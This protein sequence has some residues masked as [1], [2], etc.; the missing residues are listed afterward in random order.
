MPRRLIAHGR[1]KFYGTADFPALLTRRRSVRWQQGVAIDR[2]PESSRIGMVILWPI[3]AF[4]AV[5][6]RCVTVYPFTTEIWLKPVGK[7]S[8]IPSLSHLEKILG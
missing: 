8:R 5:D 6:R 3:R 2:R 1:C 4:H 7:A